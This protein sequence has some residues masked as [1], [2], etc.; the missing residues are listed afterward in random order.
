MIAK[1]G[2]LIGWCV[3]LLCSALFLY[4]REQRFPVEFHADE[5]PKAVQV[6]EHRPTYRQPLLLIT[7]TELVS[8]IE[9]HATVRQVVFTGRS[10]SAAFGAGA[11]VL[12]SLFAYFAFLESFL[13]AVA[14]GVAALCCPQLLLLAHYMKEDTALVFGGAAFVLAGLWHE[15]ERTA[16]SALLLAISTAV[17]ASSKYVGLLSIPVAYWLAAAVRTN[18]KAHMWRLFTLT[19]IIAWCAINYLVILDPLRFFSNLGTEAAHPVA[20]HH[21][22]ADSILVFSPIWRMLA[23]QASPLILASAAIYVVVALARW[24]RLSRA[25]VLFVLGPLVYLVLLSLSRFVLDR[26]VLP[27]T[28]AAYV[29][30]GFAVVEVAML[31]RGAARRWAATMLACAVI[32]T[33]SVAPIEAIYRELK[34]DTRL[35]LRAWLRN[36][37]PSSAVIAQDRPAHLNVADPEFLATYGS[38]SQRVLTPRDLFVTDLGSL[39]ELRKQGVTHIVTCDEAYSR[40]FSD[41]V[42]SAVARDEYHLRRA[43]YEGIFSSGKLLF[44][45]RPR[46]P[47]GGSTSPVVRVYSISG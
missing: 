15:R 47:I 32:L 23:A 26:H 2:V 34:N 11:V 29:F 28:L 10:V 14:V 36:N 40:I 16:R 20:G 18:G 43:R 33:I 13:A 21:G 44:E 7:A 46:R 8:R 5:S 4:T 9:H 35:Q 38:L 1:R 17:L 12:L 25:T 3:A 22:L 30:A 41:H 24:R 27:V 45:A 39:A 19:L 42:L 37:L 31:L 6:I